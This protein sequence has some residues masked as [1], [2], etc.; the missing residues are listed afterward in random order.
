MI[1]WFVCTETRALKCGQP[2]TALWKQFDELV[3]VIKQQ[4]SPKQ[5][6]QPRSKLRRPRLCDRIITTGISAGPLPEVVSRRV[7]SDVEDRQ[8]ANGSALAPT[9]CNSVQTTATCTG[10]Q[11][12]PKNLQKIPC[13]SQLTVEKSNQA[14]ETSEVTYL[15]SEGGGQP[16]CPGSCG[17]DQLQGDI[18]D[19]SESET[20]EITKAPT[21]VQDGSSAFGANLEFNSI[22]KRNN[23]SDTCILKPPQIHQSEVQS[24]EEGLLTAEDE[25]EKAPQSPMSVCQPVSQCENAIDSFEQAKA[26]HSPSVGGNQVPTAWQGITRM[27]ESA[28]SS[29]GHM[30]GESNLHLNP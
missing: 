1:S 15:L 21:S 10:V 13:T 28:F 8:S 16:V 9:A 17:F 19:L 25:T 23:V 26:L 24:E 14:D 18:E 5:L 30:S 2:T 20:G 3:K 4:V 7:S 6:Q 22:E 12:L 29:I 11:K 27:S